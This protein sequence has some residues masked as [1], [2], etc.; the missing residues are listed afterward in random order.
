MGFKK[1]KKVSMGT[2]FKIA[3]EIFFLKESD[4]LL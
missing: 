4:Q 2:L 3:K 1:L